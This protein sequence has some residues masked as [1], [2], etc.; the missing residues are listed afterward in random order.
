MFNRKG[1][2]V[3]ENVYEEEKIMED[4]LS[5]DILDMEIDED[6]TIYTEADKFLTVK[7][8]LEKLG[9]DKF[10]MSEVTFVP[11][12]YI[13][14]DEETTEKVVSLIEALEDID[15]VQ[16]VYHNLEM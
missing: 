12:N 14:L 8:E 3:L 11:D 13:A 6:I 9:Y 7:E 4:V 16:N 5:L 1:V 10:V 15:D 2:I